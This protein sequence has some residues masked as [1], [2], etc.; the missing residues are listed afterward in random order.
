MA[1]TLSFLFKTRRYFDDDPDQARGF[2][3]SLRRD[4][5]LQ[6]WIEHK[7]FFAV[8]Y[9]K[10]N[11]DRDSKYVILARLCAELFDENCTAIYLP[12]KRALVPGRELALRQ[13]NRMI[14]YKE[15]DVA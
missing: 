5:P 14:A 9:V 11:V 15:V 8:A 4:D 13:L 10:G 12:G 3:E 7:A 2:K 1:H 6:A